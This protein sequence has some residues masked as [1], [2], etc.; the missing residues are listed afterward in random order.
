[1]STLWDR[2]WDRVTPVRRLTGLACGADTHPVTNRGRAL[3]ALAVASVVLLA[4]CQE[5]RLATPGDLPVGGPPVAVEDQPVALPSPAPSPA[6]APDSALSAA[7]L[8]P[9]KGRAPKT[10]YDRELYGQAWKD[11]DRNGC[12]TR[13]DIL[14]RDLTAAV[15]KDGTNGCVVT[16]GVLQ[17]PY[18]GATIAFVRG[19]ETSP[20][21]QIDHVIA[22]SDSWQKGAQ[23]WDTAT[24][25]AFANDPLNLLAVDGPLNSQKGDGDAATWLPPLSAYRCP[26][27]AR[28]VGVK[29]VYG[30]WVTQ[31]EQDAM[32][33]VLST[34]PDEPLPT[35]VAAPPENIEDAPAVVTGIFAGCREAWAAGAA[36]LHRGDPGYSPDMDGD[37]DGI[38]CERRP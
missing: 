24:R 35:A 33:R 8:L 21:V 30:L 31:A 14:R 6:A 5:Q 15:L 25:E 13:N 4:G 7:A 20:A 23:Q 18:S 9:V 32:L 1:M 22:L 28:Q 26:Y 12:D 29:Q 3:L 36:P 17:D 37:G 11:V 2:P 19:P 34:C 38:A 10:G 27:V 16:A